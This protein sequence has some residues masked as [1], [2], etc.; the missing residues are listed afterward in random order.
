M[1]TL[2]PQL[3]EHLGRSAIVNDQHE[4][5][6][7]RAV[8]MSLMHLQDKCQSCATPRLEQLC[9]QQ[10]FTLPPS[11]VP[12][13]LLQLLLLIVV[14]AAA[15]TLQA[16]LAA[17]AGKAGKRL[18]MSEYG[19]GPYEVSDIRTGLALSLQASDEFMPFIRVRHVRR[20]LLL[21]L[22]APVP[23]D[24]ACLS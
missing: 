13:V 2:T 11:A 22:C 14:L 10:H 9:C 4:V 19:S 12:A 8:G 1:A 21:C 20:P 6:L 16:G 5:C 15:V 7:L 24:I 17:L 18:W 3:L 23:F